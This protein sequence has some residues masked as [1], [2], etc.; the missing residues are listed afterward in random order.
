[1]MNA[2]TE[3]TKQAP[4]HVLYVV[5]VYCEASCETSE[6]AFVNRQDAFVRGALL[7]MREGSVRIF[8]RWPSDFD[9]DN[10]KCGLDRLICEMSRNGRADIKTRFVGSKLRVR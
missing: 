8:K 6:A 5:S 7:A 2:I 9:N 10:S 4:R 1:M 3:N